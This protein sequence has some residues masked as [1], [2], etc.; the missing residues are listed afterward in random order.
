MKRCPEC[1][2][3]YYDDSLLYCLDDGSP[4]LEGPATADREEPR[5]A[6]LQHSSEL[7]QP[8]T[9][10]LTDDGPVPARQWATRRP[11]FIALTL[12]AVVAAAFLGYRYLYSTRQIR[13]IAVMPF[14]NASGD[15]DMEYI[16]DGMTE[17]LINSLAQLSQ[18][19]VK[20]RSYVFR[21]KGKDLDPKTIAAELNVQAVLNGRIVK[22]GD[23]MTISVDLV[24]AGSGD[25][26][27]GEQYTRAMGDLATLQND[28]TRDVSKKLVARLTGGEQTRIS[29]DVSQNSEAYQLYL[30]G[31][32]Q[33]NKRTGSTTKTAIALLQ[34]AIEKDPA[35]AQAYVGLAEAYAVSDLPLKQ[36][37]EKIRAAAIKAIE[38]DPSL[39][40]PHASLAL[41]EGWFERNF[42]RAEQEYKRAIELSPNYATAYHWYGEFLVLQGRFDEGLATYQKALELDPYSLAIAS[43]YGIS[44]FYARRYEE[45]IAYFKKLIDQD[46]SYYRDHVY[47]ASVYEKLGRYEEALAERVKGAVLDGA[48]PEEIS[49]REAQILTAFRSEGAKGYWKAFV[50]IATARNVGNN[51]TKN[52]IRLADYYSHLGQ[53]DKSFELLNE[54]FETTGNYPDGLEVSPQ[55]DDLRDD[56][57]FDELLRKLNFR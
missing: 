16:S 57:R 33:W 38:L 8:I 37:A 15:P 36:R 26:A 41:S 24:D 29:K 2:R 23:L 35:Y 47:L 13:S 54:E 46:P 56:P 1:R 51:P 30:Q 3:D 40:E 10:I 48:S 17:S 28:I 18:L 6:I 52:N 9:K 34:Q 5:T 45:S 32:Y 39:G 12:I 49:K 20:A 53:K 55:W 11:L 25:Q 22:R 44:L 7:D 4:L 27:W 43:D 21:Y 14:V 42:P 50:E 31:R 19:S